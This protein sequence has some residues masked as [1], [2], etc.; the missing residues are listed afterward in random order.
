MN[1]KNYLRYRPIGLLLAFFM[2]FGV[3]PAHTS[4]KTNEPNPALNTLLKFN[5]KP[6]GKYL[7]SS[8]TTQRMTF[9]VMDREMTISQ[10]VA[11]TYR[12]DVISVDNGISTIT[13]SFDKM[14]MHMDIPGGTRLS[15]DS[16]RYDE[17]TPQLKAIGEIVGKSFVM[18][19]DEE[20]RVLTTRG[21]SEALGSA[22]E[23]LKQVGLTDSALSQTL[24]QMTNIYPNKVIAIGEQWAR[25]FSAPLGGVAHADIMSTYSLEAVNHQTASI[26]ISGDIRFSD[27]KPG[28]TTTRTA[29]SEFNMTG[30]LNGTMELDIESGL[31]L[32]VTLQQN[33]SGNVGK[34]GKK[35]PMRAVSDIVYTGQVL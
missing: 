20:G 11:T 3:F 27:P 13:V 1:K 31:P 7:L 6:G 16:E 8:K 19:V 29:G 15:F 26:N 34:D 24:H 30:T 22:G 4:D 10:N 25:T 33:I 2:I 17:G 28:T 18:E 21:L 23:V 14:A 9:E 5:L 12:Y 35:M 32:K